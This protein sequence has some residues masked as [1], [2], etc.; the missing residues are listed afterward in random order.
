[1]PVKILAVEAGSPAR[2]A[3]IQPG[4]TFAHQWQ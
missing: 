4:E 2:H 3:G 1:M